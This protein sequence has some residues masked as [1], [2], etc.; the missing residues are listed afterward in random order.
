MKTYVIGYYSSKSLIIIIIISFFYLQYVFQ[1]EQEEYKKEGIDWKEI[2]FID[3]RP[4]LV[5]CF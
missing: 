1:L 2:Q 4:L 3:N 5:R